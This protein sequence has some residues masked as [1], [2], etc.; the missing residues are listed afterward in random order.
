M[1]RSDTGKAHSRLTQGLV[2]GF[3]RCFRPWVTIDPARSLTGLPDPAVFVFNHNGTF[4]CWA[5]PPVLMRELGRPLCFLVDWMYLHLPL[6]GWLIGRIDPVPVYTKPARWRLFESYRLARQGDSPLAAALDRLEAGGSL[7][8]FP[9]GHRNADLA[10]LRR[11]R[12]GLGLLILLSEAP[13]VPIG[14]EF[15]AGRRLGRPPRL[16]RLVLH[17]G[18]P[19][20]FA[21]ERVEL[22]RELGPRPEPGRLARR[23]HRQAAALG[24][25]VM[26]R[27]AALCGKACAERPARATAAP[28]LA[29]SH[30]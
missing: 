3:G 16:G 8:L 14:I 19:L 20:F 18:E 26:Q 4:E 9:E 28:P 1:P 30:P 15:P 12:Q 5:V 6:V 22:R 24:H 10:R 27:L 17:V 7:G 11:A 23:H 29:A 21:E 25:E 13:V 2:A